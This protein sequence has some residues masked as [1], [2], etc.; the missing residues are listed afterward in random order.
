MNILA[1]HTL[2]TLLLVGLSTF[3]VF[4]VG[5]GVVHAASDYTPLA[6]VPF[7]ENGANPNTTDYINALYKLSIT[8]AA[9]MVVVKL[10][11]AGVK[12]MFSE[13]VTS[14]EEAK[15]DIRNALLGLLIILSAVLILNTINPQLTNI[16]FLTGAKQIQRE[17]DT[18]INPSAESIGVTGHRELAWKQATDYQIQ[19]F[20]NSCNGTI[21]PQS[22][23]LI[24]IESSTDGT[25]DA[26]F[27][28]SGLPLTHKEQ[29][30]KQY[31]EYVASQQP[32]NVDTQAIL[33]EYGASDLLFATKEV[34][35]GN[36]EFAGYKD[37]QNALCEKFG[38]Y[39]ET[40]VNRQINLCLQ[41]PQ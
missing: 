30:Q 41:Y 23:K 7:L 39:M 18:S 16:G 32:T 38:G 11:L 2:Y 4:G 40:D 29:L 5:V 24:C 6:S 15:K 27:K 13:M 19:Q 33:N 14:K 20:K 8:I 10:I 3:C 22:T 34:L 28:Q 21:R 37:Q 31:D 17:V 36:S 26:L 12:Y 9:L 1:K 25:F 35:P